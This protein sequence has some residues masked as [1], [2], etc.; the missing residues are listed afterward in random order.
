[1]DECKRHDAEKTILAGFSF[2]ALTAFIVASCRLLS[3]LW[4]FSL[5]PFFSED[6]PRV[7]QWEL[8][9]LGKRRVNVARNISFLNMAKTVTCPVM[10]FVG[11]E[12]LVKW[13]EMK[14]RFQSGGQ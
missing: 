3:E 14:F 4:L 2:G 9:Q 10:L 6:L 5:S 13:P 1:M 8:A 7:K 11:S 12:E